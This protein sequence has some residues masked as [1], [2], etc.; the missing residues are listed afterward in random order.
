[1]DVETAFLN[2]KL[3]EDVYITLPKGAKGALKPNG[4]QRT[5]KL[6]KAL[7]GL[8]QAPKEWNEELD[9]TLRMKCGFRRLVT[10]SCLY[11]RDAPEGRKI[12]LAVF[13]DD[14]L[15][16][17]DP[18]NAK[19]MEQIKNTLKQTYTI[20]DLGEAKHVLGMRITRDREAR[21][22]TL[23]QEAYV[24]KMLEQYH[25]TD[26]APVSTPE[27][28][29]S[30]LTADGAHGAP[31]NEHRAAASLGVDDD[32]LDSENIKLRY[33]SM[34][35]S[36]LYA[37]ISTRPDIQ[38]AVSQLARFVSNP[39]AH[40]MRACKRVLR[41][42]KG[43]ASMGLVFRG[44]RVG[45]TAAVQ[46]KP[47]FCDASWGSDLDDRRSTT[48]LLLKI[49]GCA[50]AWASKKQTSVA[51]ST[52]EAEYVALGAVTK[53]VLWLRQMLNELGFPQTSS[54]LV[55]GDND[56]ANLTA[57]NNTHHTRM[58]HIDINHHFIR[59]HVDNKNIAVRWVPTHHQQA[60]I[61]TKALGRNLF[62]PLR[63]MMMGRSGHDTV[64]GAKAY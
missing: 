26:C 29:G 18:R 64:E 25:M 50:V 15:A 40:H 2:A 63:E 53:Q 27:E 11:V 43:T 33:G 32:E 39:Q 54:T 5:F 46:L 21:T 42:L 10:D 7:Y 16:A 58:K 31:A 8:K 52:A 3:K 44:S 57:K 37:A 49:N 34:V 1:M 23:D 47:T 22:L 24:M 59:E 12:L 48:G 55:L 20:S 13:V 30:H 35:G 51:M 4:A 38:H 6:L 19:L 36:L 9:S 62:T 14:M 56:A 17:S 61:L 41:Y 45:S 28:P 60:D